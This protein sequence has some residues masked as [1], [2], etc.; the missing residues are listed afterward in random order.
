[1]KQTKRN[2]EKKSFAVRDTLLAGCQ[3]LWLLMLYGIVIIALGSTISK[4]FLAALLLPFILI[5][6]RRLLRRD[7]LL[8]EDFPVRKVWWIVCAAGT[9]FLF[10][11]AY[12]VRVDN[13]SWDWGKV[14]RSASEYVL[15]GDLK[16]TIYFAR[17]PNNQLWYCMLTV[18]FQ[19]VYKINPS[20]QLPV[21]YLVSISLGCLMVMMTIML[22][23]HIA[24]LLWGNRKAFGVGCAAWLC[25]PLYMWAM[26]AYSDTLGMLLL[27]VLLYLFV[28]ARESQQIRLFSLYLG[29][30]GLVGAVAWKIKVTVFIFVIAA[31][32]NLLLRKIHIRT[33]V[34]GLLSMA[35]FFSLGKVTADA[36]VHRMLPL[37]EKMCEQYEFPLS[38]W[39]MMSMEYGGYRQEDV[40]FTESFPS[41]REK[42]AA[43]LKEIKKRLKKKGVL[44]GLTFFFYDKQVRTW[45]D[46]TFA[47]C[48]YLSRE[49]ADPD[50]FLERFVTL[51]GDFNWLLQLQTSLYYGLMLAGMFLSAL[52]GARKRK[53]ETS[54]LVGNLAMMGIAMFLTIWECNSRYLVVFLPLMILL[55]GEGYIGWRREI[56]GRRKRGEPET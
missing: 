18:V 6:I 20:A 44:G 11:V 45:G 10:Y 21:F 54:L 7:V 29:V 3:T 34:A 28:K 56:I 48:E 4:A 32:L 14:I 24:N 27:M 36:W 15:T 43:N 22:L 2:G 42:Q 51:E 37:D 35:L 9:L 1:M 47:G 19:I 38:H 5:G 25:S 53:K 23:H 26:Y 55:S 8:P 40:D 12:A 41:Y 33:L 46:S 39:V 31:V 49:P 17:Y 30:F 50:G 13:L 52:Y 16:D